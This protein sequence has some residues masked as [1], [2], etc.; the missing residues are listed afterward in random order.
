M[1]GFVSTN[2]NLIVMGI[3]VTFAWFS[4]TPE[5]RQTVTRLLVRVLRRAMED[6]RLR[7]LIFEEIFGDVA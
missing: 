4:F 1:W 2:R 3:G 7:R 6:E 5:F